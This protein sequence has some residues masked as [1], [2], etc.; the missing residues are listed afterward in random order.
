M[1]SKSSFH[2]IVTRSSTSSSVSTRARLKTPKSRS[3]SSFSGPALNLSERSPSLWSRP[4][5][6]SALDVEKSRPR[7]SIPSG[8]IVRYRLGACSQ[9]SAKSLRSSARTC[10]Y[11]AVS[12]PRAGPACSALTSR[13][14]TSTGMFGPLSR[15]DVMESAWRSVGSFGRRSGTRLRVGIGA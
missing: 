1:N 11:S 7:K 4:A 12:R 8:R 13:W 5:R 15:S 10:S 9:A 3:I 14:T 2:R 6:V